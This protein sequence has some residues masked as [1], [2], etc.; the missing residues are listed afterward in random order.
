ML[1]TLIA[2]EEHGTFSAAADAVYLTH[3]A[4]SQ[5]MKAL[6]EQWGVTIFD[7]SHRAPELTPTGRALVTKAKEVI[8]AYDNI[9]PSVIGDSGL[10]GVLSLGAVPTTLTGLVPMT[11]AGLK[12]AYPS[13]NV[14]VVPGLTL[15]LIQHVERGSVDLAVVSKPRFVPRNLVWLDIAEEPMELL[16]SAETEN[17]DPLHLLRT[18]PFIRFSRHAV[19]GAT[20]ETWLQE[21][22]ITVRESM[23]LEG[24]E[25]ISSMVMF[26]LGVSIAP[27]PCI[28]MIPLPVKHLKLP[29]KG[30]FTRTLG[31]ICRA[32]S[33]K[34]RAIRELH[35][36]FLEAVRRSSLAPQPA[37]ETHPA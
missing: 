22:G 14:S 24:L 10:H 32:D 28:S 4:V 9:V 31:V 19:V 3:A 27:R 13:L 12:S 23:E 11:I 33:V 7:R 35:Q 5:Q 17:D 6:E 29:A 15:D 8:A 20:I 21:K 30:N 16:V 26:N 18:Q 34:T 1:R 36:N 37:K 25:A 2:V